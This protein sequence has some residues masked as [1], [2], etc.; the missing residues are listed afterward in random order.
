MIKVFLHISIFAWLSVSC[1]GS[2]AHNFGS[3]KPYPQIA[4]SSAASATASG[5]E[6]RTFADTVKDLKPVVAKSIL[7]IQDR[8][9]KT[10]AER[11]VD[12]KASTE[13]LLERNKNVGPFHDYKDYQT[14]GLS[15]VPT[16]VWTYGIVGLSN[17]RIILPETYAKKLDRRQGGEKHAVAHIAGEPVAARI[18]GASAAAGESMVL[19]IDNLQNR[20]SPQDMPQLIEQMPDPRYFKRIFISD[21]AN[22]EDDWVTQIYYP[23]GFVSATAMTEGVLNLYKTNLTN[24]LRRDVMHEWGHE[25]RYK[26]WDDPVRERFHDACQVETQWNPRAYAARGDSEQWAV[27]GERLIGT[28]ADDFIEACEKAPIRTSLWMVALRKCLAEVPANCRSVDHM[29]YVERLQYASKEARGKAISELRYL[30]AE[31]KTQ[32]L[33]E[34]ANRILVYLEAS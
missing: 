30:S 3:L 34:Q 17:V 23:K 10:Q 7:A 15:K 12:F 24:H 14:R 11:L 29:S 28:S 4:Q 20:V 33:R 9:F 5:G 22:P 6:F 32:S 31:G 8:P 18:A 19:P 1:F 2:E 13:S 21:Q 27:L 16:E 26:F 25:L